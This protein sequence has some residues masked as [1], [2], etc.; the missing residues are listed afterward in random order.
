MLLQDDVSL[1]IRRTIGIENLYVVTVLERM[2]PVVGPPLVRPILSRRLNESL[3]LNRPITTLG[4]CLTIQVQ[5]PLDRLHWSS[6]CSRTCG[7]SRTR[8]RGRLCAP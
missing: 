2:Q 1:P 8:F 3:I 5:G 4:P 6:S 7:S